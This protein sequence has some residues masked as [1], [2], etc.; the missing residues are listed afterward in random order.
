MNTNAEEELSREENNRYHYT[1]TAYYY[2]IGLV[3]NICIQYLTNALPLSVRNT[4]EL[5]KYRPRGS[6]VYD[7]E[8]QRMWEKLARAYGLQL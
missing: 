3:C 6:Y 4:A 1:S 8:G 2:L 7:A 5:N